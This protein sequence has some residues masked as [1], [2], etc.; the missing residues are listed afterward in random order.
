MVYCKNIKVKQ[1][2]YKKFLWCC[3][4]KKVIT[5]N[6]CKNCLK[7]NFIKNKTI[8]KVSSKKI[9]VKK[10]I[11]QKVY[12]RDNGICRLCGKTNIE[13]HHIRYRSERKD[14]INDEKNCIMLCTEC[15]QK[16][17][18][19]KHYWQPILLEMIGDMYE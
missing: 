2:K 3:F 12:E 17:H 19:N 15:H 16:V 4:Y 8:N 10:V 1:K 9:N 7:S 11:Y 13:L 5:Y 18:S 14:L 6:D